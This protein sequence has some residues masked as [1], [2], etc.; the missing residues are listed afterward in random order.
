[1][2]GLFF[3]ALQPLLIGIFDKDVED[4]IAESLPALYPPLS[5]ENMYFSAPY[6]AKWLLDGAV[7]G[8]C[9]F[10]PLIY[11]VAAHEDVYSKEGWPGGVEEYG[12][13]FF[14]M[15]ALVADIRVTVTVAYYMVIFA[16]CMAVE[17]V[18]L[19]AGEF[20]YTELHNLAGSN[21]SVHIA[22]KVYGD[23][24]MYIFIFFSIG[25][26]VVYTLATQ[27][28]VQMFAPWMNAS[29][30][31]DAVRR[32]PFRRLHHIEKERLR[33]EYMERRLMQQLD[34]VKAKEGAA[35]A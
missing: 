21:W 26:F 30:A 5:R 14:T 1:M 3:A 23:A 2:Y 8:A 35:P 17:I 13:I 10:F 15:I 28:Y 19:P 4:E 12:L 6:I 9:F 33:R 16:V 18:V 20:A 29:V 24:K 22:R 7:E 31:M 32:S 34:E 25:V 11:T 27:L